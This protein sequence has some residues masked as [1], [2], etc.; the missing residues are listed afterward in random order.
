VP[1][2]YRVS[3]L[4]S[5]GVGGGLGLEGFLH[6]LR[7]DMHGNK[8]QQKKKHATRSAHSDNWICGCGTVYRKAGGG[9]TCV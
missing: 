1:S 9:D 2:D 7:P 8:K 4:S 3:L 6:T 5:H